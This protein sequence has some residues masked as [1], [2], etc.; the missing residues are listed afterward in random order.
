MI[1]KE[2]S[3]EQRV[4]GAT[5]YLDY[6]EITQ[7]S[8]ILCDVSNDHKSNDDFNKLHKDFY[9][10]HYLT[11]DGILIK[12]DLELGLSIL[13]GEK[14]M[15]EVVDGLSNVN[16]STELYNKSEA[17]IRTFKKA[18]EEDPIFTVYV[19]GTE[20]IYKTLNLFKDI[21]PI[22]FPKDVDL[23][24]TSRENLLIFSQ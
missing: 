17:L 24:G 1:I 19:N 7:I 11:K 12:D 6:D 5:V 3:S 8:N 23:Y 16:I 9:L 2:L 13:K 18:W 15:G 20:K 14:W 4:K 10:L 21:L 22:L